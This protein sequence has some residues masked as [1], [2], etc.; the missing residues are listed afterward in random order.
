MLLLGKN[1]FLDTDQYY[2]IPIS[3]SISCHFF[4]IKDG[5]NTFHFK[6]IPHQ[7]IYSNLK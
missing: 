4:G 2:T 6:A 1:K 3:F 5:K 7:F